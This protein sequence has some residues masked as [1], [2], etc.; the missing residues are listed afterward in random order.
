[1]TAL[2]FN[3][4]GSFKNVVVSKA[5]TIVS[6]DEIG[7]GLYLGGMRYRILSYGVNN[8]VLDRALLWC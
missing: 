3:I 5:S 6:I 8:A 1:M 2:I 7:I 4:T